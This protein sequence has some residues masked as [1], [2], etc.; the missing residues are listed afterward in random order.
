MLKTSITDSLAAL[1]GTTNPLASAP[2]TI[3]G[4]FAIVCHPLGVMPLE[5]ANFLLGRRSQRLPRLG[6]RRECQEGD[7]LVVQT[8]GDP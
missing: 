6:R 1:L 5:T 8:G 2:G 7:R 3:R 4:D